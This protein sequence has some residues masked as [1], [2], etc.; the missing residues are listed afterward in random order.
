MIHHEIL[1]EIKKKRQRG[2]FLYPDY[3]RYSISEIP[4]T[5]LSFFNIHTDRPTLSFDVFKNPN[6]NHSSLLF[7]FIDGFAYDHLTEYE[8]ELPFFNTLGDAAHIF[9]LTSVFPSTTSAALTTL[10]TGL[11]PQEH[12]LPEWTIYFEELDRISFGTLKEKEGDPQMLFSGK[13]LYRL[14]RENGVT[15]YVFTYES[16]MPSSYSAVTQDGAEVIT[17]KNLDDL[18]PKLR[19]TMENA[20]G[21]S[22]YF[23][24]WADVDTIEHSYGPRSNEHKYE[25][26]KVS[27]A[28]EKEFK[29]KLDPKVAEKT[30][31]II[32]SDHGQA[33]IK[34]ED[35]IYLNTYLDL[36]AS[37]FLTPSQKYIVPTGAPHDVFLHIYEPKVEFVLEY[38]RK[39]L[40]GKADVITTKEALE[41]G[42]FGLYTP[43]ERFIKRI[44]NVLILPYEGYHIWYQHTPGFFWKQLGIHGGL[45][46]EEMLVPFVVIDLEKLLGK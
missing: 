9:P 7:F 24:Y 17:F 37:Y 42:L 13:S 8:R 33:N 25:L 29:A 40:A 36:E 45:S 16:Y 43:T 20:K 38:L 14:L 31:M 1:E 15:P 35:I 21:P 26:H 10:Q 23:V 6:K 22:Y 32:G 34:N 27:L 12:G 39:E 18:F 30:L 3:G 28:L 11:T 4:P 41:K 19:Q 44:G 5:I 46:R 2:S